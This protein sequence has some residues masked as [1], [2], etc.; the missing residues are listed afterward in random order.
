MRQFPHPHI[1]RRSKL[2]NPRLQ[3][4]AAVRIAVIVLVAGAL[5]AFLL[6][7]DL[8]QALWDASYGGHFAFPTTFRVV[9]GILA[10][11]L[12]L[13][14]ALVFAGGSLAFFWHVR[15][16]RLGIT[17]LE[18]VLQA[19]AMGDLSSPAGARS[20]GGL[21]DFELEIDDVRSYTFGLIDEVRSEV[22]ALRT[23]VLSEEEFAGRWEE[24]KGK[25]GRIVP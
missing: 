22:K 1:R 14:F 4:G 2:V 21:I 25:I 18:K 7:R 6:F 12:V 11:W 20:P 24:L 5:I 13:L 19:S 3:G 8:R 15:G 10:R 9:K 16:I 17:R 23:P